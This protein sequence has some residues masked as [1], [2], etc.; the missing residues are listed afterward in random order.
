VHIIMFKS[1]W[2]LMICMFFPMSAAAQVY[3]WVDASG[4]VQ[5]GDRPPA[6]RNGSERLSVKPPTET[7]AVSSADWEQK[8]RE[9]R[10]RRI[11]KQMQDEKEQSSVSSQ[12]L[13]LNARYKLQMLDGKVV[14]RV[15]D[16]GE[17]VYMED[18]ERN[19]I[20][21]KAQQDIARYCR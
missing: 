12:Q 9:F 17:R 2:L 3:K 21:R 8:D 13:C 19:G 18:A 11:E 7:Q 4:K 16:K 14:Y 10:K 15:N 1:A 6:D 5:Y 20:E